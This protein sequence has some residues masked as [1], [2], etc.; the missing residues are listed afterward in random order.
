L[1]SAGVRVGCE[2]KNAMGS[3]SSGVGLHRFSPRLSER[4]LGFYGLDGPCLVGVGPCEFGDLSW[5][6]AS[7]RAVVQ[8]ACAVGREVLAAFATVRGTLAL[9]C[10]VTVAAM[11]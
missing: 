1:A 10:E 4:K 3:S 8:V 9:P 2:M 7:V 5:V 6:D 11:G